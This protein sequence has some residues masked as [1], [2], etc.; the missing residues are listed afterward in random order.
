MSVHGLDTS[1]TSEWLTPGD[2]FPALGLTF[3]LDPAHPGRNNPY[4]TVP[5]RRIYTVA[6][7]GLRQPWEGLVF[8]NPPF[9]RRGG[10]RPWLRKFFAHG[11]GIALV[12]A[13]TSCDWFHELVVPLLGSS[14]IVPSRPQKFCLAAREQQ[15]LGMRVQ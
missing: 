3:D 9:A 13:Y 14:P 1:K 7:D 15:R 8:L 10:K 2:I 12:A 5:A 4:C 11:N 6:D